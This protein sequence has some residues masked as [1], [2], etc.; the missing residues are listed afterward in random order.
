MKI[1]SLLF[2]LIILLTG[3]SQ[4]NVQNQDIKPLTAE[5]FYVVY[6]GI[7]INDNYNIENIYNDLS[8]SE[9]DIENNYGLVSQGPENGYRRWVLSYPNKEEPQ[10]KI[11]IM[12]GSLEPSEGDYIAG[13]DLNHAATSRGIMVGSKY[14]E[15][16]ET[17]GIPNLENKESVTYT[18]NNKKIIFNIN[19]NK[20]V[21]EIMIDYNMEKANKDQ[22]F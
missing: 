11:S 9:D 7:T 4:S 2:L 21:T 10:I 1:N 18:K 5:D 13:I 20:E 15:I 17:Y 8:Y 19:T 3:C 12:G 6:K 14:E 22:G 16:I